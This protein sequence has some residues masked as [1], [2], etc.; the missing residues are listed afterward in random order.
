MI[1]APVDFNEQ[2]AKLEAE[3][4]ETEQAAREKREALQALKNS[5]KKDVIDDIQKIIA[6]HGLTVLDLFSAAE[7]AK[8]T[9][10]PV[11][12]ATTKI[13]KTTKRDNVKAR[14]PSA[15]YYNAQAEAGQELYLASGTPPKWFDKNN[16]ALKAKFIIKDYAEQIELMKK[17]NKK[18]SIVEQWL[19]ANQTETSSK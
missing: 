9:N 14:R 1:A 5:I 17:Y 7:V 6:Q 3:L 19:A 10:T 13:S 11:P 8:L 15:I 16:D 4:Q 18:S 12:A 2:L